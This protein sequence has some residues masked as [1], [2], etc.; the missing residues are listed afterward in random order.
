MKPQFQTLK[1]NSQNAWCH[2]LAAC[3]N[4]TREFAYDAFLTWWAYWNKL[5]VY[6]Q[7]SRR[8][9]FDKALYAPLSREAAQAKFN[10]FAK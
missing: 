2:F 5:A 10:Q 8:S 7:S 6:V 9:A 1:Y 4:E 3:Q